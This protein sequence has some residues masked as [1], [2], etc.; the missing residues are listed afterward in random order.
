MKGADKFFMISLSSFWRQIE[1][2][3]LVLKIGS[4]EHT[5]NDLPTSSPQKQNL[6]IGPYERLLPIYGIKNPILKIGSCGWAFT[7]C[8]FPCNLSRNG[9]KSI[10]SCIRHVTSCNLGLQLAMVSENPEHLVVLLAGPISHTSTQYIDFVDFLHFNG[11]VYQLF[12][13]F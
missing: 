4:C 13:S 1:D 6:E 3:L 11:S 8:N 12:C 7:R 10:A 9:K 2:S 5:T